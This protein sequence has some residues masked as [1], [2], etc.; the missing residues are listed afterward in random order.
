MVKRV[1]D[2][3]PEHD[4]RIPEAM[5]EALAQE[6]AAFCVKVT[7]AHVGVAAESA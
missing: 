6:D 4:L 7:L 3:K 5:P 1:K 2:T